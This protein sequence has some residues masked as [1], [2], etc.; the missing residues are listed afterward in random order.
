MT[1][2]IYSLNINGLRSNV[3]Q[4]YIKGFISD[5]DVDILCIQETHIDNFF[6]AKRIEHTISQS[7]K[8]IWSYGHGQSCGTCIIIVNDKIN[9][10]TFQTDFDGRFIYAD[11]SLFESDF[12]VCTLY[13]PNIPGERNDYF[14]NIKHFLVTSRTLILCGDFNFV[15]NTKLDKIGGNVETG[16]FGSKSFNSIAK[17][18]SLIDAFRYRYPD[19]ISTTWS[20]NNIGCRID[21]FYIPTSYKDYI[22]DCGILPCALLSDHDFIFAELILNNS[23]NMGK[24][25][26]KLNNSILHDEDF[27]KSFRFYWK[28]ISRTPDID[29]EWWDKMKTLIKEFCIDYSKCKDR[30]LHKTIRSVSRQYQQSADINEKSILKSKLHGLFV[31]KY[32]GAIVRSKINII[33]SNENISS[34]LHDVESSKGRKKI[35]YEINDDVNTIKNTSSDLLNAFRNF[36]KTLYTSEAIDT[37]LY[38]TFLDNLP[39]VSTEDNNDLT[40]QI[41]VSDIE[42]VLKQM[43][44]TKTP[45]SDGLTSLFYLKFIDIFGPILVNIFNLCY[46]KGNMSPSQ[47]LSYITLLCKDKNNATSMRNYRPI[48]LLNIDRKVLSKI[49]TNRLTNVLPSLISIS[50]TCSI[51]GRSIFDNIH[52]IRN[53]MD[54]IV[55]L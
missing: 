8:Y 42:T 50:Q 37:T 18:H 54:Y 16:M 24:S 20:R 13:A 48:S 3:K 25:Y 41:T 40:Q 51:K 6:T 31:E 5:N 35:I 12:R 21:R 19:K 47:K 28:V 22:S 29:L 36:Y 11:I 39:T 45:G 53:V 4:V 43:D 34:Y 27:V 7:H 14:D 23:I 10:H 1:L 33:D 15:V 30:E 55:R 32:R 49:I 38:A 46:E 9:L 17:S 26:W 2:N 44:H 52:L